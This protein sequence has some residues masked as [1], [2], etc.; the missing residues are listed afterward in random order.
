MVCVAWSRPRRRGLDG[1]PRWIKL[2]GEWLGAAARAYKALLPDER[3]SPYLRPVAVLHVLA[4]AIRGRLGPVDIS[5]VSAK[6]EA[7]LDELVEGV[8]I[9]APII[10]GDEAGGRVDLSSIDFEKL[11]SLF[12]KQ[13]KTTNERL[14]VAAERQAREMA[15][16]NPTRAHLV[17]KLEKLVAEYNL[18]TLTAEAFFEALKKLIEEM[19]EEERRAAREGLT[20]D[21]LAI[22]DLLTKP[23]PKLTHA[24]EIEV[25]K[26][27]RELLEKLQE[28][29]RVAEWQSRPQPRAAVQSTIRF[30]LNEL[31][32]E[33]YPE[34]IW[35][36]K[37]ESVW[38]F[39]FSRYQAG[40]SPHD[41]S[42]IH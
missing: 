12:A 2:I 10:V 8:A 37:V 36:K 15:Q 5:K 31:P 28:Q 4:E 34:A 30:T 1:H 22:L 33:P 21:E 19:D 40:A 27:A 23:E 13:P 24:Q 32:E 18:A 16:T 7:L 41:S 17:E 9:T 38:Q 20:Q 39:V 29:L 3:A 14:K 6:I 25:K 35:D 26:V 11:A 42:G